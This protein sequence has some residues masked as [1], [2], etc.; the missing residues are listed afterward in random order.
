[1]SSDSIDFGIYINP[2][3]EEKS[4][5]STIVRNQGKRKR[6]VRFDGRGDDEEDDDDDEGDNENEEDDD[7]ALGGGGGKRRRK[8]LRWDKDHDD[9]DD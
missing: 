7:G 1:M 9:E 4:K 2:E 5:D 6:G 3:N 8:G